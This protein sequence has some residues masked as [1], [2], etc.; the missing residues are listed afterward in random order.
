MSHIQCVSSDRR[1]M[2]EQTFLKVNFLSGGPFFIQV[3]IYQAGGVKKVSVSQRKSMNN[4][5]CL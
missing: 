5:V 2:F 4:R 3:T 1:G